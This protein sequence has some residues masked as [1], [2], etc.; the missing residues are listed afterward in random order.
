MLL[1]IAAKLQPGVQGAG[2]GKGPDREM[3][4]GHTGVRQ[5]PVPSVPPGAGSRRAAQNGNGPDPAR[6]GQIP[7]A[8]AQIK[9]PHQQ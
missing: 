7:F 1:Q 4:D 8:A 9:L 6:L 3:D 5:F 2:G